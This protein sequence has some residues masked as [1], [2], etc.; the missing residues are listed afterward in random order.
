MAKRRRLEK[1]V[2]DD[3]KKRLKH[4]GVLPFTEAADTKEPIAGIYW[5]PV[6]GPFAV[7]GVHDFGGV[8]YGI[9]WSI[10]TKAPDNKVDATE[11][12]RAFQSAML[13]AGAISLVGVRDAS[14]VDDLALLVRERLE[15]Q[16]QQT[17]Q[18]RSASEYIPEAWLHDS[19]G[20]EKP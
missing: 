14:A 2:K 7:H 6:Q 1:H 9:P 16:L 11:P 17:K 18:T 12:Q 5:M 20:K 13:K 8:W 10:E 15:V 3:V 19:L 4:Y